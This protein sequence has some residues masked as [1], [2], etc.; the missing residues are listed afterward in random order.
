[1]E[2]EQK[3]GGYSP[4][5]AG[6]QEAKAGA[7]GG[8]LQEATVNGSEGVAGENGV[9]EAAANANGNAVVGAVG[10]APTPPTPLEE[11]PGGEKNEGKEGA[12]KERAVSMEDAGGAKPGKAV[13]DLSVDS[14][15]GAKESDAIE[16]SNEHDKKALMELRQRLEELAAEGKDEAMPVELWGVPLKAS[17][18][19][20]RTDVILL[21]FLRARDFKVEEALKM[22]KNTLE[23]RKNYSADTLCE[24]EFDKGLD[25]VSFMLGRDKIGNPVC[26]NVYGEFSDKELYE[27]TF[28]TDEG[29]DKFIRWRLSVMEE[30]V[31][32]L[33]FRPQ[34]CCHILQIQ[35]MKSAPS[36]F[37]NKEQRIATKRTLHLLQ[38]HYPELVRRKIFINVPWY[39][40]VVYNMINPFLTERQKSKWVLASPGKVTETLLKYIPASE[41]PVKYG[42][43]RQVGAKKVE[44]IGTAES[45]PWVAAA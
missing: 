31:K 20:E 22:L 5:T 16:D 37:K 28:G 30:G 3:A 13:S 29:V 17:A 41:L 44:S 2:G 10:S 24:E 39:F 43:E 9:T 14:S 15:G 23:W 45:E 8:N 21:K 25:K 11:Q 26:Y 6:E 35:D 36:P 34:G 40:S 27:R 19:D 18:G 42:G 12:V 4:L 7:A 33:D 38:D 1:M 32:M